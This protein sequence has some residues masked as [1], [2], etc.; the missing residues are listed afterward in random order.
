MKAIVK[1]ANYNIITSDVYI[2]A[3]G[4]TDNNIISKYLVFKNTLIENNIWDKITHAYAILG[5]TETQIKF[6]IKNGIEPLTNAGGG[7]ILN[8]I[9]KGIVLAGVGNSQGN[10]VDIPLNE[11][12]VANLASGSGHALYFLNEALTAT[13]T[14]T[15]G[16][17]IP[18]SS[19]QPALA[20]SL[21]YL[22]GATGVSP[23]K[24]GF[25]LRNSTAILT[26]QFINKGVFGVT[27]NGST[28]EFFGNGASLG[29]TT[30][31]G[32]INT[33]TGNL[34]IGDGRY[35][36]ANTVSYVSFG[37][38]AMTA[39]DMVIYQN[40]IKTLIQNVHGITI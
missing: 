4:I 5:T 26:P 3:S 8:T 32:V 34:R 6:N 12:F 20:Q 38:I 2:Q 11:S 1:N 19:N 28:S 33:Y 40:A 17:G 10:T 9:N 30:H 24:K 39:S 16:I 25:V 23:H 35:P 18:I 13:N 37:N 22:T 21:F 15:V 7:T 29:S 31:T 27:K 14:V 36:V